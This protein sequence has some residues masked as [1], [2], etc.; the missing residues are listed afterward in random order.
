VRHP[1]SVSFLFGPAAAFGAAFGNLIADML[2]GMLG[3]GSLFGFVGNFSTVTFR[4]PCG[5]HC[6]H[7]SARSKG[8]RGL[9]L[10]PRRSS[11]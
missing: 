11:W 2:G 10:N 3:I 8:N 6:A 5:G 1:G 9:V 7:Y 4:M